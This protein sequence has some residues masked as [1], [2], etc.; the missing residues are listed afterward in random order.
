MVRQLCFASKSHLVISWL[1]PKAHRRRRR[2]GRSHRG[3]NDNRSTRGSCLG[4]RPSSLRVI[5]R[6]PVET[7]RMQSYPCVFLRRTLFL[8]EGAQN[9]SRALPFDTSPFT[10]FALSCFLFPRL[11]TNI[12]LA[13]KFGRTFQTL[14]CQIVPF[15]SEHLRITIQSEGEGSDTIFV[16]AVELFHGGPT[17]AERAISSVVGFMDEPRS[18]PSKVPV[19]APTMK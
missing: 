8:S 9:E 17:P 3:V 11:N 4:L 6:I 2:R 14:D 1:T 16:D 12:V 7:D 10:S 13:S 15:R 18:M 19:Q 5:V